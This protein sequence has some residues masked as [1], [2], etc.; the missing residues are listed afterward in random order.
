M[1]VCAQYLLYSTVL[2][3]TTVLL[4]YCPVHHNSTAG[5]EGGRDGTVT[6]KVVMTLI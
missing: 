4:H 1:V 2:H 3:Y 5:G 6:W